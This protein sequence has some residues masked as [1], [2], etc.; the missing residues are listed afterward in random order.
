MSSSSQ[1]IRVVPISTLQNFLE[2]KHYVGMPEQKHNTGQTPEPKKRGRPRKS[3][4][5]P[6]TPF[7]Q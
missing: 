1:G 7:K 3:I 4:V 2:P 6:N 5:L